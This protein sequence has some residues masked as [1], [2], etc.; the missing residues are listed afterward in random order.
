MKQAESTQRIWA[1]AYRRRLAV[2]AALLTAGLTVILM[3]G[4]VRVLAPQVTYARA[5]A[6][7]VV[8]GRTDFGMPFYEPSETFP[9]TL[10]PHFRGQIL[11]NQERE[12]FSVALNAEGFR[13]QEFL[14]KVSNEVRVVTVGDSTTFGIGVAEDDTYSR[15]LERMLNREAHDG[16]V[17][18]VFNLG[19]GGY[20]PA[21]YYL[22]VKRYL[23]ILKPDVVVIAFFTG[24]D[25]QDLSQS[26]AGL[27]SAGLPVWV[28][29]KATYVDAQS[30]L[31][32]DKTTP[33]VYNWPLVR[34]SHLAIVLNQFAIRLD[35][36]LERK[37]S[38]PLP[39][40]T[41]ERLVRGVES[42]CD[43][44]GAK[45]LWVILPAQYELTHGPVGAFWKVAMGRANDQA[46][47]QALGTVPASRIVNVTPAFEKLP[48]AASAYYVDGSHF[49]RQGG[50]LIVQLVR[51][52]LEKLVPHVGNKT[53]SE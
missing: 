16:R 18:R 2:L 41:L 24:N 36:F 29:R 25:L 23:S 50:E 12:L 28:K 32:N 4:L 46:F 34:E 3:E 37:L 40:V 35:R 51:A 53:R 52:S 42:L 7:Y 19:I 6:R 17:F 47:L 1:P 33:R 44:A 38:P 8:N 14:P 10:T 22:V 48:G 31:R 39:P 5:V 13:T 21:E 20:G 30:R 15:V 45:V 9:F 27:D 26:E 11:D 43:E 49:T